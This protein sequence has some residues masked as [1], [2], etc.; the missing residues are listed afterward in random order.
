MAI[1][2]GQR[3]YFF[4]KEMIELEGKIKLTCLDDSFTT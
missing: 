3:L 2:I 4:N 1:V